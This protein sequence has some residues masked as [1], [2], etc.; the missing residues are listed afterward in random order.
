VDKSLDCPGSAPSNVAVRTCYLI[1]LG[2]DYLA[3]IFTGSASVA[4]EIYRGNASPLAGF[5]FRARGA[6]YHQHPIRCWRI[7]V[8]RKR[9]EA[10]R[11]GTRMGLIAAM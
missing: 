11:L 9:T 1:W 6:F 5:F 2:P 4:L 3:R 8:Y 10:R 7:I